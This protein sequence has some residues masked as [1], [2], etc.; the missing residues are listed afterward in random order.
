MEM[1][2]RIRGLL[3]SSIGSLL[4]LIC[5]TVGLSEDVP[6]FLLEYYQ[7]PNGLK[8]VLAHDP[9]LPRVS[10]AV[11]YHV[12]S[13]NERVGLTGF[14]HFFEHMMF[15]GTRRVPNFDIPLQE[16][17]GAPNAFTTED[18]TVYFETVPPPYLQ[19]VLYME[20][21]RMAFLPTALDQEKFDTEREVVKNERRQSMENVP[22]GLAEETLNAYLF[23]KGHPYSWSV[24]GSMRDLDNATLDDLKQFFYEF[25]HP[26]NAAVAVV[27]NFDLEETKRWIAHYF[28]VIPAGPHVTKPPVPEGEGTVTRIEQADRVELPRVYCAWPAVAERSPD[29]PA[30]DI[31]AAILADGVASRFYQTLVVTHQAVDV[32]AAYHP[33]ELAGS[34]LSWATV[35]PEGSLTGVE[36]KMRLELRKLIDAGPTADELKRAVATHQLTMLRRLAAPEPR[37]FALATGA[38]QYDDPHYYQRYFRDYAGLQTADIQRVAGKY[39]QRMPLVLVVRPL[40]PG[41]EETPAVLVGPETQQH[42]QLV[43]TARATVEDERWQTLP[44]PGP[45]RDWTIPAVEEHRLPNGL[46]VWLVEQHALPVVAVRLVVTAGTGDVPQGQEGLAELVA[47]VWQRGTQQLTASELATQLG[48]LGVS[49]Q[50]ST[51]ADGT[52]LAF[53]VARA[54]L[55][56]ALTFVGQLLAAPRL[57]AEEIARERKILLSD[58]QQ[59]KNNPGWVAGRVL[60]MVLYPKDHPLSRP[61]H[62]YEESL[63]RLSAVEVQQFY[64]TYFRPEAATLILVGDITPTAIMDFLTKTFGTWQPAANPPRRQTPQIS[65]AASQRYFAVDVPGAVQSV[66]VVGRLW[67]DRRA[68]HA[69]AAEVGNRVVGGDFLSR[70]N[71]NLRERHGYTYGAQSG[72]R[73]LANSGEWVARTAVR[74]DVTAAALREMLEEFQAAI[75]TRPLTDEEIA[76]AQQAEL[77]TFPEQF[78]S[79]SQWA[80]SLAEMARQVVPADFLRTVQQKLTQ[81]QPAEVRQAVQQLLSNDPWVVLLVGD[82]K[83]VEPQLQQAGFPAFRWIDPDGHTTE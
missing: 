37:A 4:L 73:Y 63:M 33:F 43:V 74:A 42:E 65:A 77:H 20:A 83:V 44:Q 15:R 46:R 39:L 79:P 76:V 47:R 82:R 7:L 55:E 21:E 3:G 1:D 70:L 14:A 30:L 52:S 68:P 31:L 81:V 61:L 36:E 50:T 12:G 35:A 80:D 48:Q 2:S 69:I 62:G 32:H 41:E 53:T 5:G 75:S 78:E 17:G 19:R 40:K 24:I 22:Y 64:A 59:G 25:Y 49:L 67:V 8:V 29:A 23:P 13:K 18:V 72:F 71:Q 16:A 11:A 60:P 45:R 10:V 26:A 56:E 27:G 6:Q 9:T 66:L 57:D 54:H 34:F 51:G 58:L 38:V 28:G